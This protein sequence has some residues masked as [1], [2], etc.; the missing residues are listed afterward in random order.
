MNASAA[1]RIS[2]TDRARR[3]SGRR[4]VPTL[5]LAADARRVV[6]AGPEMGIRRV[7]VAAPLRAS[8]LPSNDG[9]RFSGPRT[10]ANPKAASRRL[11]AGL[12]H[13]GRVAPRRGGIGASSS[14]WMK[15]PL[16]VLSSGAWRR[17]RRPCRVEHP[18]TSHPMAAVGE[19]A[20][21]ARDTARTRGSG[22]PSPMRF[23]RSIAQV[24]RDGA[25]SRGSTRGASVSEPRA[26]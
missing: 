15:L 12:A 17:T 6:K 13:E 7:S 9:L 21:D 5:A 1:I 19:H 20:C 18:P 23:A 26:A 22:R 3:S 4:R 16:Q 14:P 11:P 24:S 10:K 25:A 8:S 2:P